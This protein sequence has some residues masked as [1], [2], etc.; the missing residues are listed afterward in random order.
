MT[1]STLSS[2]SKSIRLDVLAKEA[3]IA[4]IIKAAGLVLIYLLQV[5][6]ARWMGRT[7]YGIYE[8]VIA[9]SLLLAIPAS[10][11]LPRTV[12]RSISE[13]RIKQ[14]WGLARGIIRGSL[15]LTLAA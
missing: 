14:E 3:S 15:F 12:M 13:Y 5:F 10:L 9:W 2:T 11:G 4:L 7:E 8:Y 6:L 1:E